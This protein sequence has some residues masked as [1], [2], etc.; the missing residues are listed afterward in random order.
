MIHLVLIAALMLQG[1]TDQQLAKVAWVP[2][3]RVANGSWVADPG[4]HLKPATRDSIDRIIDALESETTSEIA[5][6]IVDSTKGLEPDEFA[7]A[8]HRAWGVGKAARDNGIVFL[9]VPTSRA[10]FI[11][12]GYGL[13][14]VLPDA[15]V[16]RIQDQHV[17]PAFKRGEFD[18]GMLAGVAAL[19]TEARREG[20]PPERIAD[21]DVAAGRGRSRAGRAIRANERGILAA[22]GGIFGVF[23][24]GVGAFAWRHRRS[25]PRPCPNGHGNMVRLSETEDDAALEPGQIAEEKLKSIDYDVW[26][27]ATCNEELIVPH[28][29]MF[30]SVAKCPSCKYK[31]L[32]STSKTLQAATH[33]HG[34]RVR[35]TRDCANCGFHDENIKSTPRLTSSSGSSSGFS[36]GGGGGGGGGSSFGGGSGGGGGAGRSY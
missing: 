30:T 26:R 34:G 32:K 36:G 15:A 7:L 4:N 9:W 24:L 8:I 3:P 31:T 2:N 16:G 18:A 28:K 6:V 14:G 22:A 35:V 20:I 17:V 10:I 12:T 13:E 11:H 19:A 23:L 33:S 21:A 1:A 5:V 25:R 29:A 27:C